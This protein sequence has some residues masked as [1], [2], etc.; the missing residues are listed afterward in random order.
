[1]DIANELSEIERQLLIAAAVDGLGATTSL[2][3]ANTARIVNQVLRWRGL[4]AEQVHDGWWNE[5]CDPEHELVY[6]TLVRM[7]HNALN[8]DT[9]R[10]SER[11]GPALFHGG[12]NWG[13]PG[14]P[15]HP[16]CWPHYNSCRLTVEGER[17]ARILWEQHPE[18]G[19]RGYRYM[20]AHDPLNDAVLGLLT[21][22]PRSRQRDFT[23]VISG[24]KVRCQL[25]SA[26]TALPPKKGN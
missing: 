15:A 12:G 19:E 24:H 9:F 18:F 20:A 23:V 4:T 3:T 10:P 2:R 25:A 22:N 7:T 6:E 11:P 17:I 5:N 1:M 14:D 26:E 8:D 16:P 13:V 21:Y